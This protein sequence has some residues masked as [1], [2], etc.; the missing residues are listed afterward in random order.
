MYNSPI[1]LY[2]TT[3]QTIIDEREDAIFAKIQ[4]SFAVDVDKDELIRALQYDRNQ[5]EKGYEAGK[6]DAIPTHCE[7]CQCSDTI[8]CR[9]GYVWCGRIMHYMKADGFCSF[10]KRRMC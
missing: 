2:E 7:H 8:A 6:R 4:D 5:Y 9:E 1:K 3:M 10:G